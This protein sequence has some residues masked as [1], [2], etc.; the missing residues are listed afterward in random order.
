MGCNIQVILSFFLILLSLRHLAGLPHCTVLFPSVDGATE[1]C[2]T[3]AQ[4]VGH[5]DGGVQQTAGIKRQNF[6]NDVRVRTANMNTIQN[7]N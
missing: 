3:L 7:K 2:T 6:K 1:S 4:S 5:P